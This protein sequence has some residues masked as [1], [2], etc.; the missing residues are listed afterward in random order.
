MKDEMMNLDEF[1]TSLCEVCT[2]L[3]ES[4]AKGVPFVSIAV[5][6]GQ[7]IVLKCLAFE[8]APAV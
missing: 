8:K 1:G 7:A 3:V 2:V 5:V 6:Q 4:I